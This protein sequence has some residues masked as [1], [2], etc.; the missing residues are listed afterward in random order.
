MKGEPAER[1]DPRAKTLWRI[2]GT[3]NMLPLL[4]GAGFAGWAMARFGDFSYFVAL[5]PVLAVLV[6][7]GVVVGV[8]PGLRW[9]RWRYEIRPDEV[10]LQRGILWIGRTLVPLA[11]IQHVDTRQGPLQRRFGLSTVVF[12]TAAGP[13]QIPELSTP[14]AAEVR[15]RIA[16]L[17]TEQDEL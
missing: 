2:T 17:T 11:R 13:N 15:D 5:L 12:Y 9:R 7:G 10:D 8:A 16:A 4:V 14:V 1:L 6:L 3:L